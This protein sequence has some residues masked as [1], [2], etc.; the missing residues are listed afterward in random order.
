M[1]GTY[2]RWTRFAEGDLRADLVGSRFD[3]F[4]SSEGRDQGV[5]LIVKGEHGEKD[6]VLLLDP[7]AARMLG[8]RLIEGAVHADPAAI[9]EVSS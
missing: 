7:D 6:T 5:H 4:V 1:R 3:V 2:T 8:V 9:R